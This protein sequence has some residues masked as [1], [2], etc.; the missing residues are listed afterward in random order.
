MYEQFCSFIKLH[1]GECSVQE[2]M[3]FQLMPSMLAAGMFLFAAA[4]GW[5]NYRLR[6]LAWNVGVSEKAIQAERNGS[7][8]RNADASME[9]AG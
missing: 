5:K 7:G 3:L 4:K 8:G 6:P 2:R 1:V 9:H